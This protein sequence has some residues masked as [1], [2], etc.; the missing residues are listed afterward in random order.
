[1]SGA[2]RL[3]LVAA[4][5]IRERVRARSFQVT[6]VLVALGVAAA[7]IVPNLADEGPDTVRVGERGTTTPARHQAVLA[8]GRLAGVQVEFVPLPDLG[9]A[10]RGLRS[11]ELDLALWART[12]TEGPELL[13]N[14]R[15]EPESGLGRVVDAVSQALAVQSRLERAG[16]TPEAAAAALE[17]P[18]L[19][20]RSLEPPRPERQRQAGP[21]S[22]LVA[23]V[24]FLM[25]LQYGAW[26][27]YGV[28]E[29][30]SSRV[31]EVILAAVRP[32]QLL[33][34]KVLG[35]GV[36]ALGQ[37]LLLAGTALVTGMAVGLDRLPESTPATIAVALLWF[38]LGF[39]L[40]SFA[41]ATVGSLASRQEDA[42][43]ASFPI[44][45]IMTLGYFVSVGEATSPDTLLAR[46]LSFLPPTA[47]FVMPA[48]AAA[49][50]AP[51]EVPVAAALSLAAILITARLAG[52]VYARSVLRGGA[53]LKLRQ[54]W[55]AQPA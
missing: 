26:I 22:F 47:P 38:M 6:T 27:L 41:F 12:E 15:P 49:G 25:L 51:W 28:V 2:D 4:R 45:A 21:L 30:K 39:S 32:T 29:E 40:Y 16:L 19:P 31:V 53:R 55:R 33:A 42:Q 44:T 14:A 23:I 7:I 37:G 5:E 18:P 3:R 9:A 11:E 50:V 1:M 35:I 43:N 46:V 34:G 36:V 24:L 17:A 20:L 48:R 54:A 13:V 52:S 8:A 10:E